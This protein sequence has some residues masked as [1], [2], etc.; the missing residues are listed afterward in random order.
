MTLILENLALFWIGLRTTLLLAFFT[1]VAST[2]IGVVLGVLATFP[3]RFL[4]ILVALYVET[5]RD[6]PLIVT[7]FTIFFGAPFLGVPLQ[8]FPAVA[9]GLS[10]W[11]GA[12][13]AEIVRGGIQAVASGQTDAARALGLRRWQIYRLVLLPQAVRSVLPAFTGLLALIVQS[14]SLG[15]LVGATEF[16]KAGG[17]VIERSTVMLGIN[18]AFQIYGFVLLV[19]FSICSVLT[20]LSRRLEVRLAATGQ[21]AVV[22]PPDAASI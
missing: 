15:A 6:I 20:A 21:R 19:Y 7:I 1:L 2:V 10:L 16:L 11:G 12:N 4:R 9:L 5:F 3:A 14:T 13:A 18:P 8:P 17:L 22:T